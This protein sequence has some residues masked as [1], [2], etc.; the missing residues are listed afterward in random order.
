[1]AKKPAPVITHTEILVRAIHSIEAEIGEWHNKCANLPKEQR[2]TL[3]VAGT[4]GLREKLDVLIEM[5]RIETG[6]DY[7]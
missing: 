6:T 2:D 3:I 4:E 7:V 5:Y 1:M